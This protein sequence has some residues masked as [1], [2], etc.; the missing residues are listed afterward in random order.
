MRQFQSFSVGDDKQ[1]PA[2]RHVTFG[3]YYQYFGGEDFTNLPLETVTFKGTAIFYSLETGNTYGNQWQTF[4]G[5]PAETEI[6]I[7]CG[8]KDL[9]V[10]SLTNHPTYWNYLAYVHPT[11]WTADNFIEAECLN[12]LTVLSSDAALG[13]ARSYGLSGGVITSTPDN[14]TAEFTG[15]AELLALP[16]AGVM[17]VGWD[18]D[19]T[20]NPRT[21][22]VAEDV[23]YTAIF[24]VCNEC[25]ECEKC[26]ECPGVTSAGE[27]GAASSVAI[28]AYPNPADNLL[29]VTL[30]TSAS[31]HLTLYDMAGK[32]VFTQ[33]VTGTNAVLNIG[34][35]ASG[36]Y[37]LR[38][39][40]NGV[41][42][43]G[44]KVIKN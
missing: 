43:A 19:N 35:L 32:S 24:A 44:V 40:E 27:F 3:E 26:E 11:L 37:I 9:F 1:F 5:N 36:S 23:T 15:T 22:V 16:K 29:H 30:A 8:T 42:G 14:T 6:I 41:A 13:N 2:L 4:G 10:L 25:E 12:T 33:S 34:S 31:G 18:D 17:F 39:V 7:P 38:L 21:V 28:Q 20:D